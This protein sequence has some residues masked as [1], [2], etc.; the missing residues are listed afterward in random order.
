MNPVLFLY[1][2]VKRRLVS[3]GLILYEEPSYAPDPEYPIAPL[4]HSNYVS[5]GY[6]R[7]SPTLFRGAMLSQLYKKYEKSTKWGNITDWKT[8]IFI[9]A[10]FVAVMTLLY[11]AGVW[12]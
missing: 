2:W 10:A 6:T 7:I 9:I 12:K 4:S 8:V 3:V 1:N 5:K 11:F